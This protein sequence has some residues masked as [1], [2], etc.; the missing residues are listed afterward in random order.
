MKSTLSSSVA[1]RI[2]YSNALSLSLSV[3]S[4]LTQNTFLDV[5]PLRTNYYY[6][7]EELFTVNGGLHSFDNVNVVDDYHTY[8]IDWSPDRIQWLV[9][10]NVIRVREKSE[11]CQDGGVCKY[12]SSPA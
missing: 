7:G 10:D 3:M 11:A 6:G 9:D 2:I 12:P 5:I 4:V 8:T 1:T